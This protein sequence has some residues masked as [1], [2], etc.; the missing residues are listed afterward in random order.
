MT[1]FPIAVLRAALEPEPEPPAPVVDLSPVIA[2]LRKMRAVMD[3]V[4]N[5]PRPVVA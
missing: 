4:A 3:V 2:E 1:S 5:Q